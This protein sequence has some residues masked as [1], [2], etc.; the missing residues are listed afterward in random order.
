MV[1]GDSEAGREVNRLSFREKRATAF[2][3]PSASLRLSFSGMIADL[4]GSQALVF[5]LERIQF[6][7]LERELQFYGLPFVFLELQVQCEP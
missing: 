1:S 3:N 2:G 5:D 6:C 4:A 7:V